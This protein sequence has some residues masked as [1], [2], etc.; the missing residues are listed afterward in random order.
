METST[1]IDVLSDPRW[2]T[3][4]GPGRYRYTADGQRY[5]ADGLIV[6]LDAEAFRDLA[7]AWRAA[8]HAAVIEEWRD[9]CGRWNRW[10]NGHQCLYDS[11]VH[12]TTAR[13]LDGLTAA[14]RHGETLGLSTVP[15]EAAFDAFVASWDRVANFEVVGPEAFGPLVGDPPDAW[16]VGLV[17]G[18]LLIGDG[19]P[20]P[21]A[22]VTLREALD[23]VAGR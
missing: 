7:A 12:E 10:V 18:T 4:G 23:R 5:L 9:N 17:F 1:S 14:L 11:F 2:P 3:G 8:D 22:F 19:D 21:A 6:S 16:A 20:L 13:L 15:D